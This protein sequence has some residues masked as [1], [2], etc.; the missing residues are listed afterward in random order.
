[1]A[2]AGERVLKVRQYLQVMSRRFEQPF[3]RLYC[4]GILKKKVELAQGARDVFCS[5]TSLP[6]N[7]HSL[8]EVMEMR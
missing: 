2:S 1:M 4:G 5:A 8:K 6:W 3:V 7:A